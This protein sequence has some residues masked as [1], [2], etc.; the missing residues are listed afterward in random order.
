MLCLASLSRAKR[1]LDGSRDCGI[2]G[3]DA[4]RP[5]ARDRAIGTDQIFVE[6]PARRARF[7]EL[8]REPAIKRM[9]VLADH[10]LLRRER[11]IDLVVAL[12]KA[13]DFGFAAGFL[14]A[15]IIRRHAE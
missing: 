5:R 8:A 12:A 9:G 6:I 3:I 1:L 11:E 15:E 2:G 10:A 13:L 7:A 14:S 4:R